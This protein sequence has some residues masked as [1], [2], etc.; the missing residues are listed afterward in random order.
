MYDPDEN[1]DVYGD[2]SGVS[3]SDLMR[4]GQ[5][6]ASGA[7]GAAAQTVNTSP[8]NFAIPN[9]VLDSFLPRAPMVDTHSLT[10]GYGR[11]GS[12]AS[13]NDYSLAM[14][15]GNRQDVNRFADRQT[16]DTER[17]SRAI[18][19][20]QGRRAAL[21]MSLF[22]H[23]FGPSLTAQ[24]NVGAQREAARGRERVAEISGDTERDVAG[25][26]AETGRYTADRQFDAARN[27]A[28]AKVW[29]DV[30]APLVN[31]EGG[32]IVQKG[33]VVASNPRQASATYNPDGSWTT[34]GNTRVTMPRPAGL[35][36]GDVNVGGQQGAPA[37]S[38]DQVKAK[39]RAANPGKSDAELVTLFQKYGV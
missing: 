39:I 31:P 36:I 5:Q 21:A 32:Q 13:A 7:P 34:T 1:Q 24:G 30:N 17:Q 19:D 9:V 37:A 14:G 27:T 15:R 28:L 38:P 2:A 6:G 12:G 16:R 8:T 29:G 3:V 23:V 25:M 22:E 18:Q 11:A 33:K 4:R 10:S 26:N 20:D 35:N